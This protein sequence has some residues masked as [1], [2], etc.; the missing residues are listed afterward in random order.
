[1]NRK[2]NPSTIAPPAGRY[3]HGIEVPPGARWLYVSGQV[4]RAPDGSTPNTIGEQTENC[5]RNIAAILAEAGMSFAD[6]VKFT[7]LLTRDSDIAGFREARDRVI[8]E[9][10]PASTLLV[11]SRLAQPESLVEIE[12]I[13]AKS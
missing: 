7:V 8:G 11:V 5:F 4:G 3:T 9:A 13:A 2:Y 10:R 12:A 6:V 1:M